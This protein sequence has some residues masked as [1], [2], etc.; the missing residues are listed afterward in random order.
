MWFFNFCFCCFI[1]VL[2]IRDVRP[3]VEMVRQAQVRERQCSD[4]ITAAARRAISG[5]SAAS[6]VTRVTSD[7]LAAAFLADRAA[8]AALYEEVTRSGRPQADERSCVR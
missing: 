7:D 6:A 4:A 1:S 2:C 8:A 3:D 5:S